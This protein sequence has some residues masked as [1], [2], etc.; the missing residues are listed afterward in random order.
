MTDE[1]AIDFLKRFQPLPDDS[2]L[3]EETIR[4]FDEVRIHFIEK[5]SESAVPL[6]L[7]A[8]GNGNGFGVYQLVEDAIVGVHTSAVVPHIVDA[9]ASPHSSVRYWTAQISANYYDDRLIS[10]LLVL[11]RDE[12]EDTRMTAIASI[13]KYASRIRKELIALATYEQNAQVKSMYDAIL[14]SVQ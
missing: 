8:F 2:T 9:L 7:N 12:S 14:L 10:P 4:R 13:E 6:L 1:E 5:P 3:S 11:L